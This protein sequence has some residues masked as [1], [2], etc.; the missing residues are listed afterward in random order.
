VKRRV[1]AF[2]IEQLCGAKEKVASIHFDVSVCGSTGSLQIVLSAALLAVLMKQGKAAH[3]QKRG[4]IRSFPTHS[5]RERILDCDMEVTAELPG[6]RV[7][8]RD[9]IALQPGSVL[10]LRSPVQQAG[11]L[12]AG[13][14]GV[15]EAIP[16][17]TGSQRAAQLGR[18]AILGDWN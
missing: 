6:L 2:E 1:K 5:I 16:V 7:T 10:K 11:M 17:R 4:N 15:F 12:T 8:V 13:G 3:A 9:L 18:R 14:R